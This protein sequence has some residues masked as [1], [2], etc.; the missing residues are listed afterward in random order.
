M[1]GVEKDPI[2]AQ[3]AA[4]LI[5]EAEII[6]GSIEDL[7]PGNYELVIGNVPFADVNIYDPDLSD[8]RLAL[9]NYAITKSLSVS[10][11]G[12]LAVLITSSYTLDAVNETQ[13]REIARYGEFIGAVRLNHSTF[14][15]FSGT[16]VVADIV[17]LR[18]RDRVLSRSE[19]EDSS[20]LWFGTS[21]VPDASED[22]GWV[23]NNWFAANPEF[24]LGDYVASKMYS[25]TAKSVDGP[26]GQRL[27]PKLEAAMVDLTSRA[28]KAIAAASTSET[29]TPGV[30]TDDDRSGV[31][32]ASAV[33]LPAWSKQGSIF[34]VDGEPMR[35]LGAELRPFL[36]AKGTGSRRKLAA[37]LAVRDALNELVLAE[38]AGST[39]AECDALRAVLNERYE[40]CVKTL[41]RP[42]SRM[43]GN[44]P[45]YAALVALE[46]FNPETGLATR[47]PIFT[48]RALRPNPPPV[49]ASTIE[50]AAAMSLGSVGCIDVEYMSERLGRSATDDEVQSVAFVDPLTQRHVPR[51]SYLSGNVRAKLDQARHAA[52]HDESY[53]ANVSALQEVVPA[54]IEPEELR[55]RIGVAW[56]TGEEMA[57]FAEETFGSRVRLNAKFTPGVGWIVETNRGYANAGLR[58]ALH[59]TW[60]TEAM[61]GLDLIKAA[62]EGRPIKLRFSK[63]AGGGVDVNRTLEAVAKL[64]E[65]HQVFQ[66]WIVNSPAE[67]R[68]R[69]LGRYNERFRSWIPATYAG[70]WID[71]PQLSEGFELR[72]A[73]KTAVMATAAVE[74]KRLG[75]HQRATLVV[76][77]HLV[78][79]TSAEILR[80]YPAA[81]VLTPSDKETKP[82]RRREFATRM[83]TGD[84]D[85]IVM[86]YE[87][88]LRLPV[89]A[90]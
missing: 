88:F 27:R 74:G 49:S 60:G 75:L 82:A 72:A 80:L 73:G 4:T 56:V 23:H 43:R 32:A 89:S 12:A 37:G 78:D 64:E 11:P 2:S 81:R 5:D 54:D 41:G 7:A 22:L 51:A 39:D 90:G 33:D 25:G 28:T 10:A 45:D 14:E 71:P 52:L 26:E 24:M 13:R 48:K 84:W 61:S 3:I 35:L 36:E 85:A 30:E 18:R 57:E 68:D 69:M 16:S 76:P 40:A 6:T 63:E 79:Q 9:H 19:V 58:E 86:S 8:K 77:N 1:V 62:M 47:A 17:V 65:L 70:E 55:A 46:D 20:E 50:E 44:D 31:V 15:H 67:R 38:A 87:S 59:T 29:T 83:A 42:L 66:E 21:P 53:L 34:I